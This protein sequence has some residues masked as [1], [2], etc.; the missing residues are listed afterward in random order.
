METSLKQEVLQTIQKN[1]TSQRHGMGAR[2]W[3]A[4]DNERNLEIWDSRTGRYSV[5]LNGHQIADI[6]WHSY[7]ERTTQA[8]QDVLDIIRACITYQK[9]Q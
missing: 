5:M 2:V 3:I 8:Q 7:G 6:K 1:G 4:R 9:V